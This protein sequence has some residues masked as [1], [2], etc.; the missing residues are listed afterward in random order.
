MNSTVSK[1]AIF[2]TILVSVFTGLLLAE[3]IKTRQ[4]AAGHYTTYPSH[5]VKAVNKTVHCRGDKYYSEPQHVCVYYAGKHD[6]YE[7]DTCVV[8]QNW[9]CHYA[10][11]DQLNIHQY[12]RTLFL[13]YELEQYKLADNTAGI[14]MWASLLMW[15]AVCVAILAV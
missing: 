13:D 11:G 2:A 3:L 1:S 15:F 10:I 12:G 9:G 14:Q 8:F 4:I 6:C 7:H 5:I